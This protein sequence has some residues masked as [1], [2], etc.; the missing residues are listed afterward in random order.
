M[1][2]QSA[3]S[4]LAVWCVLSRLLGPVW[5]IQS[6][7]S[8]WLVRLALKSLILLFVENEHSGLNISWHFV[9][10]T[11]SDHDGKFCEEFVTFS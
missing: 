11:T 8:V 6:G 2:S 3:W 5:S 7:Q 9:I 4:G 1:V 10:E